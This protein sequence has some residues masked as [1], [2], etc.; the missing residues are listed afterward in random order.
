[1]SGPGGGSGFKGSSTETPSQTVGDGGFYIKEQAAA[2]PDKAG[3]GQ[4]WIKNDTPNDLYFVNDAG[5]EVRITNGSSIAAAAGGSVAAD[6]INAGDNNVSISTTSGDITLANSLTASDGL[7]I[8]DDTLLRFG[9]AAGDATIE[10][11]E[12]GTDQLRFAGASAIFEQHVTASNSLEIRGNKQNTNLI[13]TGSS[14]MMGTG[15]AYTLVVSGGAGLLVESTNEPGS[16]SEQDS[17]AIL[18]LKDAGDDGT[19]TT[20]RAYI[21]AIDH[22]DD[23]VWR[24]GDSTNGDRH[25][26]LRAQ[27]AEADVILKTKSSDGGAITLSPRESVAFD[28]RPEG[29]ATFSGSLKIKDNTPFLK[30]DSTGAGQDSGITLMENGTD[31]WQVKHEG[32]DIDNSFVIRD[33]GS[34]NVVVIED[35]AGADKLHITST[36][37]GI[38]DSAPGTLL[39]VKGADAYLTLQNSTA[40]NTAAGCETKVIFEDHGNNA[41]GQIEV[42][43]V[44][45]SDDEKGQ[46]ILSTN[47]DSGLQPAIT[48]SDSQVVTL[49]GGV[50]VSKGTQGNTTSASNTAANAITMNNQRAGSFV[51]TMSSGHTFSSGAVMTVQVNNNLAA[52]DDVIAVSAINPPSTGLLAGCIA[53]NPASGFFT[54]GL[55]NV[56]AGDITQTQTFTVNWVIL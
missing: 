56:G 54:I 34:A 14:L 46:M 20:F 23:A 42:S 41:L 12:N 55:S 1:M 45:T 18:T 19:D 6:D 53:I 3:F 33:V 40:E 32:S 29:D 13:V 37:V 22:T 49:D 38:G 47:N 8:P 35:N 36:G 7:L 21:Q 17:N 39:Q 4:L 44:G 24:I 31:H 50:S 15:S 27:V 10:Y 28:I 5:T 25:L 52:T 26:D 2:D 11:D 51:V 43:H 9:A 16:V 30:I 48:I